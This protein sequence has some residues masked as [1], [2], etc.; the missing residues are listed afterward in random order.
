MSSFSSAILVLFL[1]IVCAQVEAEQTWEVA[2]AKC[3][4][5]VVNNEI[6]VS[7]TILPEPDIANVAGQDLITIGD[8]TTVSCA[9]NMTELFGLTGEPAQNMLYEV[10]HTACELALNG[11]MYTAYSVLT[12]EPAQ[13]MLYEVLHTACELALNGKMYTCMFVTIVYKCI[14]DTFWKVIEA[15]AQFTFVLSAQFTIVRF[16]VYTSAVF[17]DVQLHREASRIRNDELLA[18]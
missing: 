8:D 14:C 2:E 1:C 3:N 17:C 9:C 12:G 15:S 5:S 18:D 16:V 6:I 7:V 4:C 11:E 10:L 13:N